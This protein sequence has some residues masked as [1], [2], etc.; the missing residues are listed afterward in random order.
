MLSS[1][2]IEHMP[3]DVQPLAKQILESRI[4]AE[5]RGDVIATPLNSIGQRSFVPAALSCYDRYA[6]TYD[7]L[8]YGEIAEL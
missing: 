2:V 1:E 5:G 6:R 7:A 3:A 4:R 8:L